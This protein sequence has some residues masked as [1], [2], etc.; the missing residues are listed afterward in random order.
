MNFFSD[1]GS[2]IV[3]VSI[4]P[5]LKDSQKIVCGLQLETKVIQIVPEDFTAFTFK[6]LLRHYA[7]QKLT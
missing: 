1:I 5:E 2:L 3:P 4:A 6:T 7:K